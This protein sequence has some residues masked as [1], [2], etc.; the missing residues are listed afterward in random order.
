[1]TKYWK[2]TRYLNAQ[3]TETKRHRM[4]FAEI[5]RVIGFRLPASASRHRAWWSSS[6]ASHSQ[7]RAW[8]EAG[9][10][11]ETVDLSERVV[12]FAG[13]DSSPLAAQDSP[14]DHP[15]EGSQG[16][17][18]EFT[19][20]QFE[21]LARD[22]MSGYL[23]V[24]LRQGQVEGVPKRF[25]LVSP[26]GSIVGDAK[27]FTMVRGQSLPPAKFSVIA[28]YVWLLEKTNA[29]RKFLVFGNDRRVPEEWLRRYGRLT[30]N[31]EYYFLAAGSSEPELL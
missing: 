14:S 3:P 4:S 20:A 27:Y 19:P 11:V 13:Q 12:I 16:V 15:P 26:D 24:E 28:E 23:G 9:W 31:V 2:L 1:M 21:K 29:V 7:A 25:D 5:E 6:T 18:A 8:S 30:E 10:K 22:V 17:D